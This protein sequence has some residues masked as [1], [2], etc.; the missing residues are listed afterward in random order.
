MTNQKHIT[1]IKHLY[2]S[3]PTVKRFLDWCA[4]RQHAR[5]ATTVDRAVQVLQIPRPDV[6]ALFRALGETG[7]GEFLVG[8]GGAQSRFVWSYAMASVGQVAKGTGAPLDPISGNEGPDADEDDEIDGNVISHRYQ[9]RGDHCL[10]FKLPANLS[11]AE[12]K[13]IADFVLTLPF[14]D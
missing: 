10:E 4:D 5:K 3:N 7:V 8:R 13:R 6:V 2:K 14:G 11:K 9:V 1:D 12:A